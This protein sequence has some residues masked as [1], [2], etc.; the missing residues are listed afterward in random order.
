MNKPVLIYYNFNVIGLTLNKKGKP[1]RY[2]K[3]II[4]GQSVDDAM[5]NAISFFKQNGQVIEVKVLENRGIRCA[6]DKD[7]QLITGV[8]MDSIWI[9]ESSS[10]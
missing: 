10:I 9:D 7:G 3:M 4:S 8:E 6:F 5:L 2:K 1:G